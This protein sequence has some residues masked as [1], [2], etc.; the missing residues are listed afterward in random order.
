MPQYK[1]RYDYD[2]V[3]DNTGKAIDAVPVKGNFFSRRAIFIKA[4]IK[5]YNTQF[6]F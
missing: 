3:L 2:M 6:G 1:K 5:A 4:A